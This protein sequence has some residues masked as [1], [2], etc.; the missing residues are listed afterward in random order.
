M[1]DFQVLGVKEDVVPDF[2]GQLSSV[3]ISL[4]FLPV[5]R[6]MGRVFGEFYCV[7]D[8]LHKSFNRR[9]C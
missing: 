3:G 2:K 7:T 9:L 1:L 4:S 8:V 6:G 5:T